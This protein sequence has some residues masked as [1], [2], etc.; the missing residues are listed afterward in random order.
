ML[1]YITLRL[2]KTIFLNRLCQLDSITL[3]NHQILFL[4]NFF[5]YLGD[6]KNMNLHSVV[7]FHGCVNFCT[8]TTLSHSFY[9]FKGWDDN[10]YV[11]Y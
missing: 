9:I 10:T 5:L 2:K 11:Q 4:K 1:P 6:E 7:I 8:L 3:E